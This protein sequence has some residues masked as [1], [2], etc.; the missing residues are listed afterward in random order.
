MGQGNF[1]EKES[2]TSV[3]LAQWQ[4][5]V[6]MADSMSKRRDT[7][8]HIFVTIN[9][10]LLAAFPWNCSIKSIFIAFLGV[11]LC[12][13]WGI[14]IRN[15]KLLNQAKFCVIHDLEKKLSSGPFM[16]EW[17]HI[18]GKCNYKEG[19]TLELALPLLFGFV[20]VCVELSTFFYGGAI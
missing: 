14:F 16:D 4:T 12:F 2:N 9:L 19:T 20:Y 17:N 13:L 3:I 18:K 5:C 8:N 11:F 7:T 1:G 10:A 15:Y 6:Q